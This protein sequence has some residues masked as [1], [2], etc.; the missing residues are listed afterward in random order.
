MTTFQKFIKRLFDLAFSTAGLIVFSPIITI[1][2]IAA[3]IDF[4]EFGIFSQTR[5]GRGGNLFKIRKI[6]TMKQ[7]SSSDSAV[8][9]S[10]DP[11]I[12]SL[13]QFMRRKKLDELPQLWCVLVGSM[14]FVGP[15]PDVKGFA[16]ELVG[17]ERH[18]LDIRPGITGPASIKY[19]SEELILSTVDDPENYNT[20]VIYP[21]KTR[22]NIEYMENWSLLKDIRYILITIGLA[23][24]PSDLHHKEE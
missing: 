18:I 2:I 9:T 6:R 12:S 19:R 7:C 4:A 11:R 15:R 22:I 24:I 5:V 17:D 8:T 14:S 13:G 20:S 21:D 1:C 10:N 3:T 23:P 16:D